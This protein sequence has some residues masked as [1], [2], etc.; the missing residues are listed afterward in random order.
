M[1]EIVVH[2]R[3]KKLHDLLG[4]V[5]A[6]ERGFGE[7]PLGFDDCLP[8]R[9]LIVLRT[10]SAP[11]DGDGAFDAD[12][13]GTMRRS[14]RVPTYWLCRAF[15]SPETRKL[16]SDPPGGRVKKNCTTSEGG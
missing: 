12:L 11:S 1:Q 14:G 10:R 5:E 3:L 2:N 7:G 8:V 15:P 6:G 13:C 9:S 16:V 4:R